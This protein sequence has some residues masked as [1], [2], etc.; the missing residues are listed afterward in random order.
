MSIKTRGKSYLIDVKV[1][2]KRVRKTVRCD[3]QEARKIESQIR[4]ELL[5]DQ[6]PEKGLEEALLKYTKEY[7]PHLKDQRGQRSKAKHLLP[8]INGKRFNDIV[9]IVSEL[10]K[11]NLKPATINRR[12]ALLRRICNLAYK[13]WGWID[14]PVHISLLREN[15]ERHIYLDEK[16]VDEL[17]KACQTQGGKDAVLF[18]AYTGLRRGEIFSAGKVVIGDESVIVVSE[19]KTGK[20]RVVPVHEKIAHIELPLKTTDALL[21]KDFVQAREKIGMPELHFHDLRH[22]FASWLAIKNVDRRIIGELLGQTQAQTTMRYS[23]LNTAAL[24]EAIDKMG[25]N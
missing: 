13:E 20:P 10:K 3:R 21:R 22:T 4:Q 8:Y 25:H 15:N 16:T 1:G 2:Q 18:A 6:L 23:H 12:L 14:K 19:T 5:D 17:V 7:I 9:Q 24:R 11:I